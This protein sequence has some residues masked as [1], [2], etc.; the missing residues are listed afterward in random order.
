MMDGLATPKMPLL[1]KMSL[2][3]TP[4]F[5]VIGGETCEA[6]LMKWASVL[7]QYRH[8]RYVKGFS[9]MGAANVDR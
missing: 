2:S 1:M 3:C 4:W 7:G 5:C 6:K 9:K 8:L